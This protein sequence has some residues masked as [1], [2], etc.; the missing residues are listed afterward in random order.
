VNGGARYHLGGL[1]L[2][3]ALAAAPARLRAEPASGPANADCLA[4]HEDR[5]L[6]SAGGRSLAVDPAGFARSQHG[7]AGV[8]C[9]ACHADL[10]AVTEFPH[11]EKLRPAACGACHDAAAS[12][13]A[14]SVHHQAQPKLG[15]TS[16]GCS[17]CHDPH[18]ARPASDPAAPTSP[19]HIQDLCL[20]CH[21]DAAPETPGTPP[22]FVASY[23]TSVHARALR[24][25]GL[26]IAATCVTCH[27]NHEIRRVRDRE[28]PVAR[29]RIAAL[30]GK[31]HGGVLADYRQSIHGSSFAAGN[32]RSPVCTDCHGEHT[33]ERASVPSSRVFARNIPE[34]CGRCHGDLRL[35]EQQK[36]ATK[37]VSTFASSFHG[38]ALRFGELT[39]AN[40]ASCH[41]YHDILPAA[42]P[43]SRVHAARLPATCGTCHP[44]AGTNWARG[45]VHTAEPAD[46]R[47]VFF[48]RAAYKVGIEL[49]MGLFLL[50]IGADLWAWRRRRREEKRP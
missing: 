43:R 35:V 42:D 20:G 19:L 26:T 37:R 27:G 41:G 24:K 21:R 23:E 25:S 7:Q 46:N 32:A 9:V 1:V 40:C 34:T 47:A 13:F 28:S 45:K 50:Y 3:A 36:L 5:S 15:G 30:C 48:T 39:T 2:A 44:N 33:V 22:G 8:D 31:C 6:K 14:R 29:D 11:P 16:L 49:S 10:A 4:C 12:A 38:I 17:S 18:G